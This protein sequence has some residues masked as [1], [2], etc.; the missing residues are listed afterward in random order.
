MQASDDILCR[1][2]YQEVAYKGAKSLSTAGTQHIQS[3]P[4]N[5][6]ILQPDTQLQS[7]GKCLW[8]SYGKGTFNE[9]VCS[10]STVLGKWPQNS[11]QQDTGCYKKICFLSLFSLKIISPTFIK[12][13]SVN[14]NRIFLMLLTCLILNETALGRQISPLIHRFID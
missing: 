11:L 6:Q 8:T 14:C 12:E 10:L 3:P 9:S 4:S 13:S 1:G 2:W 5:G 7:H